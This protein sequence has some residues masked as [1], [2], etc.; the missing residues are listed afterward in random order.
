MN[1][2]WVFLALSFL[3]VGSLALPPVAELALEKV[4]GFL[5]KLIHPPPPKLP[6][7]VGS[8]RSQL[9]SVSSQWLQWVSTFK[10]LHWNSWINFFETSSPQIVL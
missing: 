3:V 5:R 8:Y 6:F 10:L 1:T 4:Q 2:V 7:T 9:K